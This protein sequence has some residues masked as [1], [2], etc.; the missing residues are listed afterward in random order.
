M[1]MMAI[2]TSSS[3]KVNPPGFGIRRTRP[4]LQSG[5][6]LRAHPF[7]SAATSLSKNL[8]TLWPADKSCLWQLWEA[9]CHGSNK[10]PTLPDRD[11]LPRPAHFR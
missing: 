8:R 3:I 11:N 7:L 9:V 5:D 10:S 1:P 6:N 2:T 4:F